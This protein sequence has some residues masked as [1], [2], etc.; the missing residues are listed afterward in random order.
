L[1]QTLER[2]VLEFVAPLRR[3]GS[4]IWIDKMMIFESLLLSGPLSD[5]PDAALLFG[6]WGRGY[7]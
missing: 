2:D 1:L 4:N 7:E 6:R 3:S 5:A